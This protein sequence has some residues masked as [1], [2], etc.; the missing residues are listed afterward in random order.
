MR[1]VILAIALAGCGANSDPT[2]TAYAEPPPPPPKAV[3]QTPPPAPAETPQAITPCTSEPDATPPPLH[4]E[5][6]ITPTTFKLLPAWADDHLDGAVKSFLISCAK[7]GELKDSDPVGVDG[8]G[9]VARQW[10]HACAAAAS[11]KAG[12]E[13]AARAMFEA[14]FTPHVAA[15]KAGTMGKLTGYYVA[16]MHASRKKTGKF[17]YPVYGR[18]ADLVMV[19]LGLYTKDAH[20]KRAWGRLDGDGELIPYFTRK[21]IRTGVLANK[22]LELM[23]VDDP[24]DLLFAHIEGSAKAILDDGSVVWLE[25]SGKNGRAYRGVGQVLKS[26]GALAKPGSG[27]MQGIRKWFHENPT[28]FD[29]VTDQSESYVFFKESKLPG[30]VGS[31]KVILTP[32]RSAAIDRA[33]I[34]HGTPLWIEGRAPVVGAV[35]HEAPWHHLLIAQD[36]GGGILGAVRADVYWGDDRDAEEIGGRMGGPGKYWVLLPRGVTK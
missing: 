33:F 17:Q 23:Y 28:R 32:Q 15:G 10:R 27:T 35:G 2:P 7:I 5:L 30:A 26:I 11:V 12:D 19:D 6:S 21:E 16:E 20:G 4:D 22:G 13:A 3:V 18:P 9:G 24:V 14:E 36:T 34:A 1:S 29:E 31:Q 8:H 25:F